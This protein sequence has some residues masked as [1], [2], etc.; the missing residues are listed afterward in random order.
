MPPADDFIATFEAAAAAN[1]TDELRTGNTVVF[2]SDGRVVATGD[3]HGHRRNFE[4]IVAFS[5]LDESPDHHVILH[6]MI[7]GGP[8]D[9][10]GGDLS[11]VM[12]H[13][14][15]RLKL[16]Y[17]DQV[18][19]LLG[20]HDLAQMT[21]QEVSRTGVPRCLKAFNEG[22]RNMFG[23]RAPDVEKALYEFFRTQPIAARAGNVFFSHSTPARRFL[24]DF[25]FAV[26]DRTL[27]EADLTRNGSVYNLVWGR[28]YEQ[29]IADMLSGRLKADVFVIGHES[30][31]EGFGTPT[32]RHLV[33]ASDH[34][35]GVCLP[36]KLGKNYTRDELV[37]RI[38][39]LATME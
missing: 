33:L 20:N 37:K 16:K 4:K 13:E 7:H 11:F 32:T 1:I 5:K 34:G 9:D 8:T 31:P 35:H 19:F 18:H 23:A 15:C 27:T 6:E 24:A 12:I 21:G 36:I 25:D 38:R 14:A 17:P 26:F 28:N 30:Q 10:K 2:P 22:M 3:L 29:P 39:H